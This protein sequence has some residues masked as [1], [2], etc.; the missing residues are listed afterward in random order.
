ME[1]KGAL[2]IEYET[3]N[4]YSVWIAHEDVNGEKSLIR[5]KEIAH[6]VFRTKDAPPG[7]I[8]KVRNAR[9]LTDECSVQFSRTKRPE[10]VM[11]IF[12]AM[13]KED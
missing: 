13:Q 6:Y 9:K 11:K 4:L 3:G 2:E 5:T 7:F 1:T 8:E 12:I 10:S